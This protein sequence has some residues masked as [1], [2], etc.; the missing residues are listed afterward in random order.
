[1]K[2]SAFVWVAV[3]L[4]SACAGPGKPRPERARP[5]Q[6]PEQSNVTPDIGT[7]LASL[8]SHNAAIAGLRGL[9]TI[10]FGG[11]L[12]GA[13]GETSFA[14]KRPGWLRVD[15]LSDFGGF[16]SQI[17]LRGGDLTI[18][19]PNEGSYYRGRADA[20]TMARYLRVRA[21]PEEAV[22]LLLGIVPLADEG[23]YVIKGFGNGKGQ[24]ERYLLKSPA[25]ELSVESCGGNCEGYR[26]LRYMAFRGKG[27][28]YVVD[29]SDYG[30]A[31]PGV[32]ARIEARF[33]DPA[34]RIRVEYRD[35]EVNPK[36]DGKLFELKIPDDATPV[37]DP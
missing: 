16:L 9:A 10:R 1:V 32:P 7:I 5:E 37:M 26:P 36:L 27:R 35:L 11:A 12:F 4:I 22:D 23:S 33:F 6:S 29:Y 25:G 8:R 13:R 34:S 24:G 17:A 28:D 31:S 3:V 2:K 30:D 19:W 15:A 20:E 18:F 14:A 21:K